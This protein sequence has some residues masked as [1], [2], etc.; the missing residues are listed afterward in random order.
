MSTES[1][2]P[3]THQDWIHLTS[4][5]VLPG[6]L[7]LLQNDLLLYLG[8]F[9]ELVEVVDDDRNGQCDTENPT[10]SAA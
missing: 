8:L 6:G 9:I 2:L 4:L 1:V 5:P 10:E 7:V 3:E